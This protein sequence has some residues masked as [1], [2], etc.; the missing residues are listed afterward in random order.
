MEMVLNNNIVFQWQSFQREKKDK[1]KKK[2]DSQQHSNII[3]RL[4]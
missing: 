3:Y 2:K 1:K 4:D